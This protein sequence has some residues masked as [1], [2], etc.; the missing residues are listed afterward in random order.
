M[1]KELYIDNFKSLVDFRIP[2]TQLTCLIGLNGSGK[3]TILQAIDFISQLAQGSLD[4][5]LEAREWQSTELASQL[6][7][8]HTISFEIKFQINGILYAWEG[9]VDLETLTC[10]KEIITNQAG[11]I[12]FKVMNGLY[13]LG[14]N[15]E[16]SL[17]FKYQGSALS[18][19]RDSFLSEELKQIRCFLTAIKSLDLLSPQLMRKRARKSD[20]DLGLGGEKLSAFLHNLSENDSTELINHIQTQFSPTFKSFE[21]SAKLPGWKKLF[22]NE[23]FPKSQPIKTEAMHVSDG[24]LRLSY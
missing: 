8:S 10:T 24:L 9:Q 19:I 6:K 12:L 11:E 17:E 23:Q 16:K 18:A 15:P 7:Q 22:V 13:R 2:L 20:N 4:D 21:T 14:D 5:W 1:I 3:S